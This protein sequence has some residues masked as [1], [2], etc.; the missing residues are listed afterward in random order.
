[1]FSKEARSI[2]FL[3]QCF[4]VSPFRIDYQTNTPS[5]SNKMIAYSNLLIF[6]SFLVLISGCSNPDVIPYFAEL[7][8]LFT[9]VAVFILTFITLFVIL[10]Q[11][12][13][14]HN[15]QIQVLVLLN[16][17]DFT[18]M[19][20]LHYDINL[21]RVTRNAIAM[22]VVMIIFFLLQEGLSLFVMIQLNQYFVY[23]LHIIVAIVVAAVRTMQFVF[24]IEMLQGRM[25]MLNECVRACLV[26]TE[27]DYFVQE[28]LSTKQR[29]QRLQ[30]QFSVIK[31]VF[32]QIGEVHRLCNEVFGDS[33]L[34]IVLQI[35]I[36]LCTN[37]YWSILQH[38]EKIS[39]IFPLD[40]LV[41]IISL[42]IQLFL[43]V[44]R[45]TK[46][47]SHVSWLLFSI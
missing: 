33:M 40:P 18:L 14:T 42:S 46:C 31:K 27:T 5:R 35:F 41:H 10:I 3:F 29:Q 9:D 8:R 43:V 1:M 19:T 15:E 30:T 24:F 12:I 11:S 37:T 6:L 45:C 26:L 44:D 2:L 36:F 23:W 21:K 34:V 17:I 25:G 38:T 22:C 4:G 20:K 39:S 13:R 7:S 16:E 28:I 32:E 47:Q